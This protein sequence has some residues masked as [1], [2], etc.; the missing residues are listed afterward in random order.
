MSKPTNLT[1]AV[2]FVAVTC[3]RRSN[4]YRAPDLTRLMVVE[5]SVSILGELTIGLCGL[6]Q[7]VRHLAS[8]VVALLLPAIRFLFHGLAP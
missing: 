3:P 6:L 4:R 8:V 5:C 7:R 2:G 1:S